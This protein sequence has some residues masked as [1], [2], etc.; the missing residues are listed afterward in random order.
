MYNGNSSLWQ[1]AWQ[2]FKV[3]AFPDIRHFESAHKVPGT[4][5]FRY[6]DLTVMLSSVH[7]NA[8]STP[9][10]LTCRSLWVNKGTCSSLHL[11]FLEIDWKD[12]CIILD[13]ILNKQGTLNITTNVQSRIPTEWISAP[14][15]SF[16]LC[17]FTLLERFVTVARPL[18]GCSLVGV[19]DLHTHH[20]YSLLWCITYTCR[21]H[22]KLLL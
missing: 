11:R 20:L 16:L 1:Q 2:K 8:H 15:F 22:C 9:T 5:R 14:H 18:T 21:L 19:S 6:L 3:T 4:F 12:T 10:D 13:N 17:F 7:Q